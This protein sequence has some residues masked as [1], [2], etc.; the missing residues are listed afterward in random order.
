LPI[1]TGGLPV[2]LYF[3]NGDEHREILSGG[4]DEGK[5]FDL[6]SLIL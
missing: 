5:G 3:T 4:D 6:S 1:A 2:A